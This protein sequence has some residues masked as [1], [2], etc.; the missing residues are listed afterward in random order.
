MKID[1]ENTIRVLDYKISEKINYLVME[2]VDGESI[3]DII[4]RKGKFAEAD[5]VRVS[6]EALKGL[7]RAHELQIVHRDIKPDNI[8]I[9]KDGAVKIADFGIAKHAEGARSE[10]TQSGFIVGTP[11]YMSPE[12][13][14]GS[15]DHP[16]TTK[17][18]IYSMGA[19]LYFMVTGKKP[20][21]GDTQAT[22]L[23][24]HMNNPPVPPMEVNTEVSEGLNNVI[25]NMMAKRPKFRYQS[26][27]DVQK[28]LE[29]VA[30]GK[31]VKKRPKIDAP[32]EG[33]DAKQTYLAII[34]SAAAALLLVTIG[35]YFYSE[36]KTERERQARA[37][38][39]R[40]IEKIREET[41][42]EVEKP[43]SDKRFAVALSTIENAESAA[44][45]LDLD[46]NKRTFADYRQAFLD[47]RA[48][49]E[50]A[51]K[52]RDE[53][54]NAS[55]KDI[56]RRVKEKGNEDFLG[57]MKLASDIS[58]REG[59]TSRRDES[60]RLLDDLRQRFEAEA[61]GRLK[62]ILASKEFKAFVDGQDYDKLIAWLPTSFGVDRYKVSVPS[63]DKSVDPPTESLVQLDAF[64]SY[65]QE[66]SRYEGIEALFKSSTLGDMRRRYRAA[67]T[68]LAEN[69]E[70]FGQNLASFEAVLDKEFLPLRQD[71]KTQEY[72]NRYVAW[73]EQERERL[74][75]SR[76]E[77]LREALTA[78][79]DQA[80]KFLA[81]GQ[82]RNA[83]S[84]FDG[85]VVVR[86]SFKGNVFSRFPESE[87]K[88]ARTDRLAIIKGYY[89][90]FLQSGLD[91][92]LERVDQQ[93]RDSLTNSQFARAL[94]L[95]Q[96]SETEG[97]I[98]SLFTLVEFEKREM[99]S[100][101]ERELEKCKLEIE[102]RWRARFEQV[103]SL[104]RKERDF[105]EAD[106]QL[107][108]VVQDPQLAIT[109]DL[110]RELLEPAKQASQELEIISWF[111]QKLQAFDVT[112]GEAR[113]E[114]SNGAWVD[115]S[116]ANIDNYAMVR[117]PAG[118]FEL[119]SND[120]RFPAEGPAQLATVGEFLIDRTEVTL[121]DYTRFLEDVLTTDRIDLTRDD[122][123]RSPYELDT[124]PLKSHL[125]RMEGVASLADL[126]ASP[127]KKKPVYGVSW[128]SA[129]AY[130][131]WA[132]K[133]LPREDE[134]EKAA[135][136][137]W[138][139]N[140]KRLFPWGDRYDYR[141]LASADKT[142][143]GD[144][145]GYDL[146]T[147]L[148]PVGS[149]PTGRS[150]FGALDMAGNV[151]EWCDNPFLRYDGSRAS[152]S[153]FNTEHRVVRGGSF[154]DF[155][156]NTFRTTFREHAAPTQ[157]VVE[158]GFR[159]VKRIPDRTARLE[160]DTIPGQPLVPK[161]R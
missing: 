50:T 137:D 66:L 161:G 97:H 14:A 3:R 89:E 16:V 39:S 47:L 151:W 159:C 64:K 120:A 84:V 156:D 160:G 95:W 63:I 116:G 20:F 40:Q 90:F 105:L 109:I 52:S 147:H 104:W 117:V 10:L 7:L 112:R 94:S 135:C 144:R 11:H 15:G 125:P 43:I 13:C 92:E 8:M 134:W 79:K 127:N 153:Q 74:L 19:T 81:A 85:N 77:A 27:K 142:G 33:A 37:E 78:A 73:S 48:R 123:P 157:R 108:Q 59:D 100:R 72:A 102:K 121:E 61:S 41:Q 21:E 49:V 86:E 83:V 145:D 22:I 75:D 24:Q 146:K 45:L 29:T 17:A 82:L 113:F 88:A 106:A 130:A 32:L 110:G 140:E 76:E 122:H 126:R 5:A 54:V 1:H 131:R 55:F 99:V 36:F 138:R 158:R 69:A 46:D 139:K 149:R 38:T 80:D 143:R 93:T 155:I 56:E 68:R 115:A 129:K 136:W 44:R 60:L 111:V 62:D 118:P 132:G 30:A 107:R 51:K 87:W 65:S 31:S 26:I 58:L 150:P 70:A 114:E 103:Q 2:F 12:Q 53:A 119:G 152:E 25:L 34:L 141:R 4:R 71:L 98:Y 154:T 128:F 96:E 148:L 18:D 124:D 9:S 28:D 91:K 101:V 133:D 67:Q 57:A 35:L 23:L 6:R 42:G